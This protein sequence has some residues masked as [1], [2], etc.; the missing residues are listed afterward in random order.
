MSHRARAQTLSTFGP[1][2][3]SFSKCISDVFSEIAF[4]SESEK[5][6][7]FSLKDFIDSLNLFEQLP[8]AKNTEIQV[9]KFQPEYE[10]TN[11]RRRRARGRF[12]RTELGKLSSDF[13]KIYGIILVM[14]AFQ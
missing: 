10:I 6:K 3:D 5:K 12:L 9:H 1:N 14:D 2:V 8:K 11:K 7:I 4:F 13:F